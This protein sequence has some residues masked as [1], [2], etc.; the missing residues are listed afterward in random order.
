M[1]KYAIIIIM[2]IT[3]TIAACVALVPDTM[4]GNQASPLSP[5][6][7]IATCPPSPLPTFPPPPGVPP[8]PPVSTI[9]PIP[10]G[11][12]TLDVTITSFNARQAFSLLAVIGILLCA[13]VLSIAFRALIEL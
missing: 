7:P 2:A 6:S 12:G 8:P 13:I 3:L 10:A 11:G 4:A 5:I 9:I 1:K